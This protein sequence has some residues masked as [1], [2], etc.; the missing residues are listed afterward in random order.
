MRSDHQT[1]QKLRAL[2]STESGRTDDLV[3]LQLLD[4]GERL[5]LRQVRATCVRLFAYRRQQERPPTILAGLEWDTLYA[6]AAD[7]IDVLPTVAQAVTWAR[8]FVRRIETHQI[9]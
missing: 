2:S 8:A 1:A 9:G 4:K 7:G 5:D 6:E 3:D